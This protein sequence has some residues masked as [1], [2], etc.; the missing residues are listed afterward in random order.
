MIYFLFSFF[1]GG[2]LTL[3]P[4]SRHFL[5][6]LVSAFY[7]GTLETWRMFL[8]S[9]FAFTVLFFGSRSIIQK[10]GRIAFW[11]IVGVLTLVIVLLIIFSANFPSV[12]F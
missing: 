3:I 8:L 4:V 2:F 12:S 1:V 11:K 10:Q 7:G 5:D 9:G 6:L